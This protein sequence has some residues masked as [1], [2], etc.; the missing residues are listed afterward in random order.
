MNTAGGRVAAPVRRR[1]RHIVMAGSIFTAVVTIARAVRTPMLLQGGE[2]MRISRLTRRR[3]LAGAAAGTSAATVLRP[4]L[5][6]A[7]D[8]PVITHGVQSGDV[9]VDSG[10]V[11]ARADRPSRML[12]EV[13]TSESFRGARQL[14]FVDALP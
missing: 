1:R 3:F 8:R 2:L 9:S 5:S 10:V 4:Y 7:N 13:A 14:A 12:V 6:R 11:W